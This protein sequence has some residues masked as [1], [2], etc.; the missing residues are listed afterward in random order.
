MLIR[1]I[2]DLLIRAADRK[3]LMLLTLGGQISGLRTLQQIDTQF[4]QQ[5]N[6][7]R[8]FDFQ[9]AL[10]VEDIAAQ[11]PSYTPVSKA[12]YRRFFIVDFFFPLIGA[13]FIGMFWAALLKRQTAPF[14]QRLRGWYAPVWPLLATLADWGE[15]ICF[16]LLIN[17]Y[18]APSPALA[19]LGVGFKRLK[20]ASLRGAMGGSMFLLLAAAYRWWQTRNS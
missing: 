5:T 2:H 16:L 9:H 6:G 3:W 15:N 1:T 17:R 14:F 7:H 20:L 11:L 12:L 13:L 18:P 8:T 10:T 19:R 4:A